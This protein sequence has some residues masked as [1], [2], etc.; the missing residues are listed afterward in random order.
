MQALGASP[1]EPVEVEW[2]RAGLRGELRGELPKG[3]WP[4][5]RPFFISADIRAEQ[6]DAVLS[7]LTF[8]PNSRS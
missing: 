1:A 2:E 5:S 3:L 6:A 4:S 7:F 8:V